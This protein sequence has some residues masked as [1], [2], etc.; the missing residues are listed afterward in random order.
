MIAYP[1]IDPIIVQIGPLAVRWYSLAY[2]FGILGGAWY[3][4]RI[5]KKRLPHIEHLKISDDFMLWAIFGIVLGGRL[6]YVLFYN[7]SY[8]FS[9]PGEIL[10]VWQG[11]M[12]FHGGLLG[13]IIASLLFCKVKKIAVFNLFDLLA[14]AAPIGLFFGRIANFI[15]GE[16]YGRPTDASIGMIFPTGGPVPRHPS[17]LYEATLEGLVLFVILA[18]L[19]WKTNARQKA[20][21]LSAVFM[22]GYG[23]SRI[24]VENFREPDAHIGFLF[25]QVTTGQLLSYPMVL[26]GFILLWWASR[27][28]AEKG[29]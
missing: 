20:G 18:F 9:F 25:A 11:G 5:N 6:G 1:E 29:K 17:Q 22:I 21:T 13:I 7:A 8:Y 19:T 10:K 16:L 3:A 2:V 15:N 26:I 14:C 27:Y 23:A 4:D 12:S 24:I 28:Q